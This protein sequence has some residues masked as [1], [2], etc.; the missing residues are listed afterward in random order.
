MVDSEARVVPSFVTCVLSGVSVSAASLEVVN[1]VE[2]DGS[3]VTVVV[4]L[5][6]FVEVVEID[7]AVVDLVGF[8]EVSVILETVVFVFE[9][10]VLSV[11]GDFVVEAVLEAS[12]VV[13]VV[14]LS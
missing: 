9:I 8:E 13:S 11:S 1:G 10:C 4:V 12:K 2:V 6:I 7:G 3:P 14:T 5:G